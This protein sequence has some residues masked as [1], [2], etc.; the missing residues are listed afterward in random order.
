MPLSQTTDTD[1]VFDGAGVVQARMDFNASAA[2][3]FRTF[4]NAIATNNVVLTAFSAVGVNG[5]IA[6]FDAVPEPGSWAL[7]IVGL[8]LMGAIG[9]RRLG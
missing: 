7:L 5:V 8:G 4:D 9:H 3:P 2:A 6:A 1:N